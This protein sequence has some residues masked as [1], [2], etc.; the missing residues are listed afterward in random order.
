MSKRDY[1]EVLGVERNASAD[2][3]KSAYRKLALQYH[4][5][6]N[7]GDHAA[8]EKFKE[9]AEAYAA[10]GD[11]AKRQQ[12]DRFG[13]AG[14]TGAGQGGFNPADFQD[15]ADVF[16]DFFGF[17]DLF[18]GAG[19]GGGGRGRARA[20]R[21]ADLQY[22]LEIDF[23]DA[24]FG[25]ST[26]IQYPRTETCEVCQGSGAK[27]G[28]KPRACQTCGGRGQVYFQRG[29]FSVA[30]TCSTCRGEGRVV[31]D[32][33]DAC[34]GQ[35]TKRSN[36]RLKVNIP[37]G[38]D[39]G[40]RLR[41]SNEGE[42][43]AAGGPPGDLYVLIRVREHEVFHREENDL[44]CEIPVNVARAALGDEI[45]VPSLEGEQSLKI[46]AGVQSGSRFRIKGKGVPDVNSGRRGDLIVHIKVVTP[47]K[48]TKEQRKHFEALR[49][50]LPADHKP[51]EKGF[52]ERFK[53][54][55]V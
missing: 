46:N 32:P 55:F 14:M 27:A 21:G 26:E 15:F 44:H 53:E 45:K 37:P 41:L 30:Q 6:R 5:D 34:H 42:A 7:P 36:R 52:L 8:E 22:E 23:E 12:Y 4:P 17:G 39:S 35:G 1:Y 2:V 33:C 48:L 24:V 19:R 43:G 3:I 47:E 10:L 40:V 51:S 28:S 50:L 54:F 29:F 16:G 9:A 20:R 38:V 18:G 25:M 31:D 13:H 49:D 11:P